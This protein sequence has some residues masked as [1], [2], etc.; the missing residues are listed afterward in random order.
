MKKFMRAI[1][2]AVGITDDYLD[3]LEDVQKGNSQTFGEK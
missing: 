2:K 3:A 1:G